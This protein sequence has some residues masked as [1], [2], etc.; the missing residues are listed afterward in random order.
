[1]FRNEFEKFDEWERHY[2]TVTKNGTRESHIIVAKRLIAS[3][4]RP[5]R[6]DACMK[7]V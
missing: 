4:K 1:M 2:S 3:E 7:R 5:A 6:P